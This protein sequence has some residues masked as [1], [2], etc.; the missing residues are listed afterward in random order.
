MAKFG[1]Y[2]L[3]LFITT[4]SLRRMMKKFDLFFEIDKHTSNSEKK[5]QFLKKVCIG[6]DFIDIYWD[7]PLRVFQIF[8]KRKFEIH[9]KGWNTKDICQ[10]NTS[11]SRYIVIWKTRIDGWYIHTVLTYG[12]LWKQ[13][14]GLRSFRLSKCFVLF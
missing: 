7:Y 10:D 9:I 5:I 2:T 12:C 14:K 4:H 6:N 13:L 3:H 1:K 8:F 11:L